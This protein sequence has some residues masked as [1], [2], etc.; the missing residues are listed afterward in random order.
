VALDTL[1][2]PASVSGLKLTQA[3]QLQDLIKDA[4]NAIPKTEENGDLTAT[5]GLYLE[6]FF[7]GS[8]SIN[9][10]NLDG[11]SLGYHSYELLE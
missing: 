5:K 7:D 2:L 8:S 3:S 4:K 1:Y 9:T 10:I 6:G 11:G